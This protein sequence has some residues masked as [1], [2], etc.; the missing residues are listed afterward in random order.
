ME[1][2]KRFI[3]SRRHNVISLKYD[4]IKPLLSPQFTKSR[5]GWLL[6]KKKIDVTYI[7]MKEEG[8][9]SPY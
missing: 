4:K 9:W 5:Q 8:L 6:N 3:S 2:I 7:D 1:C